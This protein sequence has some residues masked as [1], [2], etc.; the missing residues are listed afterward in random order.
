M[1]YLLSY[2]KSKDIVKKLV[3]DWHAKDFPCGTRAVRVFERIGRG[4]DYGIN[5]YLLV[6][7][8]ERVK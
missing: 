3:L 4:E 5:A 1:F 7:K 6:P 8:E 2:E